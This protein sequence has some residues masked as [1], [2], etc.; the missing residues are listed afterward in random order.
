[1]ALINNLSVEVSNIFSDYQVGKYKTLNYG[2]YTSI[3]KDV[4]KIRDINALSPEMNIE[5]FYNILDYEL[6]NKNG[7]NTY[8]LKK[9]KGAF[10][11]YMNKFL[12]NSRKLELFNRI[13]TQTFMDAFPDKDNTNG[14]KKFAFNGSFVKIPNNDYPDEDEPTL[15]SNV[16]TAIGKVYHNNI[17]LTN[18]VTTPSPEGFKLQYN[19]SDESFT[20]GMGDCD[21]GDGL[22]GLTPILLY[23]PEYNK[24]WKF[25]DGNIYDDS[26]PPGSN[27]PKK[28]DPGEYSKYILQKNNT[29]FV[30]Q[31]YFS[32]PVGKNIFAYNRN[33]DV[34][35][36][37]LSENWDSWVDLH[38]WRDFLFKAGFTDAVAMDGGGS[39][40]FYEY[41]IRKFRIMTS[42]EKNKALTVGCLIKI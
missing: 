22:G 25:G 26:L 1:M 6:D 17:E 14:N 18:C 29:Q 20:F 28:G 19:I 33:K 12:E 31:D 27:P 24:V 9:I 10:L 8:I 5:Q 30:D 4:N 13:G 39:V 35:L 15:N 36:N 21:A 41:N 38:F 42:D 23:K 3:G 40:T 2:I 11:I 34:V 32:P 7:D 16:V 37:I